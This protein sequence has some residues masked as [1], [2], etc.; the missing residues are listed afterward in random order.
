MIATSMKLQVVYKSFL[1]FIR[2]KMLYQLSTQLK[3]S[4]TVFMAFIERSF[5][6]EHYSHY[7]SH[8]GKIQYKLLKE[9]YSHGINSTV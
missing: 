8:N 2:Y 1:S 5:M 9:K 7:T 6:V 4:D 3:F